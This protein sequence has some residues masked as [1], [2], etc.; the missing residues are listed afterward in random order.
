MQEVKEEKIA[1]RFL[2]QVPDDL[3]SVNKL[4][5]AKRIVQLKLKACGR[6]PKGKIVE[7]TKLIDTYGIKTKKL[8]LETNEYFTVG[9]TTIDNPNIPLLAKTYTNLGLNPKIRGMQI[10]DGG[11]KRVVW[12]SG[13]GHLTAIARN[14]QNL[15]EK[16]ALELAEEVGGHV[17]AAD[18]I[19]KTVKFDII[20]CVKA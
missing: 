13:H 11:D 3:E 17:C 8:F 20:R 16:M 4:P 19:S 12:R 6:P 14:G 2:V 5:L 7:E 18:V 9:G 1:D 10:N 15:T